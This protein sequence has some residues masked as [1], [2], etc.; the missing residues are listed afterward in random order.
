MT[1]QLR[2]PLSPQERWYWIANQVSPLNVIARVR[3]HGKISHDLLEA[4]AAA[5][6]AEYPVLRVAITADADGTNPSFLPSAQPIDVR[7]VSGDD[8]EWQRQVDS[9]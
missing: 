7:T 2:R 8:A 3:L 4:A 9:Y 1:P 5:L 6:A